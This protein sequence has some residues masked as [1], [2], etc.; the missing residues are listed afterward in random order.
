MSTSKLLVLTIPYLDTVYTRSYG[1]MESVSP[2]PA[3]QVKGMES[4]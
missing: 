3:S 4:G 1:T 2:A